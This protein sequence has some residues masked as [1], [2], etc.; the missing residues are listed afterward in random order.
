MFM[1]FLLYYVLFYSQKDWVCVAIKNFPRKMREKV[2]NIRS[3]HTG[4]ERNLKAE[5]LDSQLARTWYENDDDKE[6]FFHFKVYEKW[7]W[8]LKTLVLEFLF[9]AERLEEFSNTLQAQMNV[10]SLYA[11]LYFFVVMKF[12]F[13]LHIYNAR[14]GG[15]VEGE[16]NERRAAAFT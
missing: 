4:A 5:M 12:S 15:K 10:P 3:T 11:L 7:L 9:E 16:E 6:K 13:L 2:F 8:T 14:A 1:D